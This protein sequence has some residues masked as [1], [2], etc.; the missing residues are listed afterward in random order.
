MSHVL[1]SA[2]G[3]VRAWPPAGPSP[4]G[5]G[6]LADGERWWDRSRGQLRARG[7]KVLP[8]VYC[9]APHSWVQGEL[10]SRVLMAEV[11]TGTQLPGQGGEKPSARGRKGRPGP[12]GNH[13][14]PPHRTA[15]PWVS[16]SLSHASLV[17]G[18]GAQGC[19]SQGEW[20]GRPDRRTARSLSQGR[21][22]EAFQ[23]E[24][25]DLLARCC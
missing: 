19:L 3:T 14:C 4:Q 11:E 22:R 9:S 16:P 1:F 24:R 2:L 20:E 13:R 8:P 15:P 10:L 25:D 12:S 18:E 7:E 17:L 21:T 6:R 5:T 23:K